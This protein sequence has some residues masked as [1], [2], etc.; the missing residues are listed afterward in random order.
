MNFRLDVIL[1]VSLM[2]SLFLPTINSD[3][4]DD[5]DDYGNIEE[6]RDTSEIDDEFYDQ[7]LTTTQSAIDTRGDQDMTTLTTVANIIGELDVEGATSSS[8]TSSAEDD[9]IVIRKILSLSEKY[10]IFLIS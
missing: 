9:F 5:D 1:W 8:N 3:I 10:S 7:P 4:E 2:T 6:I